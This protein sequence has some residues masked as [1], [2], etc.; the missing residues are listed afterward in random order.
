MTEYQP[1]LGLH[2]GENG[3]IDRPGSPFL[4][5]RVPTF[6]DMLERVRQD[7]ALQPQ[8]RA[9][10]R[11]A[12]RAFARLMRQEPEMMAALPGA[13]RQRLSRLVPANTGL[14]AKR[15]SNI[16]SEVLHCLRRYG[17]IP[18]RNGL[19]PIGPTW[20]PIWDRLNEYERATLSRFVRWA[21]RRGLHPQD[22]TTRSWPVSRRSW[23]PRASWRTRRQSSPRS[24]APGPSFALP[25]QISR[26]RLSPSR[27]G[28][29]PTL[30]PVAD[31]PAS[32]AADLDAFCAHLAGADL[33]AET[34]PPRPLKPVSVKRRRFQILQLASGLVHRGTPPGDVRRLADVV[35][36]AALRSSLRFF[37]E[38]A[39]N[40]TTTQI[41]SLGVVA[42]M[43]ARHWAK[44]D[45]ETL[46]AVRKI[47]GR[48]A[49][50]QNGLT[51]KNRERLRQFD[52]PRSIERLLF[53]AEDVLAEL[54]RRD[55]GGIRE[56]L[57][58]QAAVAVELLL[59]A[60]IRLANLAA[61][62]L[63]VH[64]LPSR[65]GREAVWHL[66]IPEHETKNREPY[67]HQ[68]GPETVAILRQYLDRYRPR[69]A[70][71]GNDYLFPSGSGHKATN[72]LGTMLSE[73]V[74]RRTGLAINAHLFRHLSAKLILEATPGAY[75][76]VQDVL[77]HRDPA[78]TRGHYAGSEAAA[79]AR[80]YDGVVRA[81]R[82]HLRPRASA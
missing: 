11:S 43:V 41:A 30:L 75:G 69:L 73:K 12:L 72:S 81:T 59:A 51:S 19:G 31:F 26:C 28:A 37:M 21:S 25:R 82:S 67:E 80:H 79:A 16:R 34:G 60:P 58:A 65:S 22:A 13:Y 20:Q 14:S 48:V 3:P 35:D 54:A 64:L 6:A 62:R 42:T 78:T 36:P 61:L 33:F 23:W 71:A 63:D 68:L 17:A 45:A 50:R 44:A 77:G 70:A 32:F 66:V 2:Y 15:L 9:D 1:S 52:D 57:D 76:I 38:R 40:K 7:R 46:G 74:H 10:L 49:C 29:R 47:A 18:R 39:G 56:A 4:D 55:D 27:A 8:R 24:A 5:P 53:Y